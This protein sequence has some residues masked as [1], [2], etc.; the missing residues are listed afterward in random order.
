[1]KLLRDR[2]GTILFL[3]A[4]LYAVVQISADMSWSGYFHEDQVIGSVNESKLGKDELAS[5]LRSLLWRH[6]ESWNDLDPSTQATR[7][8]EALETLIDEHLISQRAL[9]SNASSN[10]AEP[11]FQQFLKQFEGETWRDRITAQGLNEDVWRKR[12]STETQQRNSLEAL[13]V[14]APTK[15]SDAEARAWFDAHQSTMTIPER[16][17]ARHL[18]LCGND[19][20][21]PDRSADI[22]SIYQQLRSSAGFQAESLQNT[23]RMPVPLSSLIAK[24][25][26]DDNNRLQ[27]GD[28]GWFSPDR[29][30]ADFAEHV[31]ALPIG[32]VSPPFPD[33]TRLAPRAGH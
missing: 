4:A 1:M 11:A 25:S 8:N 18:F 15:T 7:R 26:E 6:G 24:Y 28:L 10:G 29:V 13:L 9:S 27:D 5:E 33:E 12:I 30:P 2:L 3:L 22:Q 16:L 31:F 32:K 17:H 23:G 19:K 21:K 14:M 20:E